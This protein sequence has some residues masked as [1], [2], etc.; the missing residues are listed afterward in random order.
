MRGTGEI[1]T[2]SHCRVHGDK[3][4]VHEG[5]MRD[6]NPVS[7]KGTWKKERGYMRGTW[8]IKPQSQ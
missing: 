8:E 2:Q 6:Q 1:K 3:E 4:G 7:M 5:Y